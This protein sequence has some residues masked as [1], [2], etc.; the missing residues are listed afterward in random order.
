MKA[1]CI[2][3]TDLKRTAEDLVTQLKVL[4]FVVQR[5]D[6]YSTASVYLKLDYGICNSIRIS[7]HRGKK[8]L[9]YRYNLIRGCKEAYSETTPKGWARHYF[10]IEQV[11]ELVMCILADRSN[12]LGKHGKEGYARLMDANKYK[13][14]NDPGF[15][16]NAL[17]V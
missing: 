12:K 11:L 13:H 17:I 3:S 16:R 10:P 7:D 2:Q 15:W 1:N 6:A 8:H 5:Y 4:G 14:G 9:N